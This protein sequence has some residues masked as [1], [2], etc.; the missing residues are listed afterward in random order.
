VILLDDRAARQE[1]FR[2]GLPVAGTIGVLND[3]AEHGLIDLAAALSRL[4]QT[5]Y[6]ADPHL[7]QR[8]LAQ[9]AMRRKREPGA[10][11]GP[12]TTRLP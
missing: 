11:G 12:D 7:I 5:S 8:L 10:K 9:N 3:A 1:A 4:A 2:L 6:Y